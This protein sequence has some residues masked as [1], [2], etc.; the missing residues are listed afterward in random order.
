[1]KNYIIIVITIIIII[2]SAIINSYDKIPT[3]LNIPENIEYL[4]YCYNSWQCEVPE[5]YLKIVEQSILEVKKWN[6]ILY[7]N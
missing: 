3:E 1:M 2:L 4:E 7:W 6:S 5:K